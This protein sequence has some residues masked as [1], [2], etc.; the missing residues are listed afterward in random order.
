MCMLQMQVKAPQICR[1]VS[2]PATAVIVKGGGSFSDS[3]RSAE[4]E[5]GRL[6]TLPDLVRFRT[7]VPGFFDHIK[8]VVKVYNEILEREGAE[9]YGAAAASANHGC[10]PS[11]WDGT[12]FYLGEY[13]GT[14][15]LQGFHRINYG[16][17]TLGEMFTPYSREELF[18]VPFEER[19]FFSMGR[20]PL[21]ALM[22]GHETQVNVEFLYVTSKTGLDDPAGLTLVVREDTPHTIDV[23]AVRQAVRDR[24][25]PG[26]PR[27]NGHS[28]ESLL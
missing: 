9:V 3:L 19:A 14:P 15:V 26:L 17:E 6:I 24:L 18:D 27:M 5:G 22:G 28:P 7:A 25:P 2:A 11:Q 10:A 12:S 20:P 13:P 23:E 1:D 21:Y 8:E 4:E 16:A